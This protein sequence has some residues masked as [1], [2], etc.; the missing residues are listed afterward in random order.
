MFWGRR[1]LERVRGHGGAWLS[2]RRSQT[3]GFR[4]QRVLQDSQGARG[5]TGSGRFPP[6]PPVIKVQNCFRPHPSVP[7]PPP[8]HGSSQG[9]EDARERNDDGEAGLAHPE[10]Q[11][12]Q[13]GHVLS[14]HAVHASHSS[15]WERESPG[16]PSARGGGG[17][18]EP[19]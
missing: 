3:R 6:S 7:A 16:Q 13:R 12:L 8:P 17:G 11:R 2:H 14:C 19:R 4:S 9:G 1:S 18:F 5:R 15:A 10:H